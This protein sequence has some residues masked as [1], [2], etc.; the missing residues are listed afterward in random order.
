M[1]FDCECSRHDEKE[2]ASV[3]VILLYEPPLGVGG[4]DCCGL[5]IE[6]DRQTRVDSSDIVI[7]SRREGQFE[8]YLARC[9]PL[10]THGDVDTL[11]IGYSLVKWDGCFIT[12]FAVTTGIQHPA[13]PRLHPLSRGIVC[14]PSYDV[15]R[16]NSVFNGPDKSSPEFGIP[17]THA[18]E[19]IDCSLVTLLSRLPSAWLSCIGE[20]VTRIV[21]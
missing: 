5:A 19:D 20:R 18:V 11:L 16:Y 7:R 8:P 3:V 13:L 1:W 2:F 21:R 14:D 9:Y 12:L 4:F 6:D 10:S 15:L 17:D